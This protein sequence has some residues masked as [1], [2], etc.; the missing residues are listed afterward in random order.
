MRT[1]FFL[2]L[3]FLFIFSNALCQGSLTGLYKG[4][5]GDSYLSIKEKKGKVEGDIYE[6]GKELLHLKGKWNNSK[7]EGSVLLN[8][9]T[10][11][12]LTGKS[13]SDTLDLKILIPADNIFT[14]IVLSFIKISDNPKI[15]PDKV[16]STDSKHPTELIGTW[17]NMDFGTKKEVGYRLLKN[18]TYEFIG[19]IIEEH[20]ESIMKSMVFIWYVKDGDLWFKSEIPGYNQNPGDNRYGYKLENNVLTLDFEHSGKTEILFRKEDKKK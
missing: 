1:L 5:G 14:T 12:K 3:F 2:P 8:I 9:L 7:I 15:N 11:R 17:V 4:V 16:F 10:E 13:N 19:R 20:L 18:G 6:N